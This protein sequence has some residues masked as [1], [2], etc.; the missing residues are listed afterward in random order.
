MTCVRTVSYSI[1]INGLRNGRI[2]P[3][4][5]IQ[6]DLLSPYFFNLCAKGLSTLMRRAE[7]EGRVTKLPITRG[8]KKINHLFF[9]DDSLLFCRASILEWAK[10]QEVLDVYKIAF[11]QNLNQERTSIFFRKN[12]EREVKELANSVGSWS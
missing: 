6:R 1:L 5:G 8:G 10:I 4:R 12:T 9:A 2:M 7:Q 11:E 3:S